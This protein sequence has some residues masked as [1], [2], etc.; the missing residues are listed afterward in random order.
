MLREMKHVRQ[1]AQDY[2]R[3]IFIDENFDLYIWYKPDD[4]F[5]GFQ[6]CYYL[7]GA[8]KALTWTEADGFS[9][10]GIDDGEDSPG[11]KRTPMLIPDGH[12]DTAR[13]VA[14]FHSSDQ[15]LPGDIRD[16]V[17]SKIEKYEKK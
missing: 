3:R 9:H 10:H 13:V 12:F 1:V 11:K 8:A 7:T 4:T 2:F 6:L 16:F 5:H 15:N 17:R 14:Q